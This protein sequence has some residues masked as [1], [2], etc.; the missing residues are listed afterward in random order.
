LVQDTG[1]SVILATIFHLSINLTNLLYIDVIYE[2]S[3][4]IVIG[5]VWAVVAAIFVLMKRDIFI[6]PKS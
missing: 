3:F 5:F 2:T 4:M 6:T 1:F